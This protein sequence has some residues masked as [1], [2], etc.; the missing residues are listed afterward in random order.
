M[1]WISI[2]NRWPEGVAIYAVYDC[3]RDEEGTA[4]YDGYDFHTIELNRKLKG[5]LILPP[6]P[7]VTHWK[8]LEDRDAD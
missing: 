4:F 2:R 1:E 7:F 8:P 3:K 6:E 5:C